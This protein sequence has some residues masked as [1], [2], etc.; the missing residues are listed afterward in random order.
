MILV[1]IP[2]YNEEKN[3][4]RVIRGLFEHGFENIL[5][6]DDGSTDST[7]EAARL[8]G[9]SV[10]RHRINRGQGAALETGNEFARR[11]G[12]EIVVHFDADGQFNPADVR[13]AIER[14]KNGF[15]D[16]ILGSRFMDSRSRVPWFKKYFILPCARI[17]NR[18]FCGIKL[19][20]AHNGFRLLNKNALDKIRI[21]QAGMAHNS[22]I[23][24]AIRDHKLKYTETPVEVTYKEYGQ[25]LVGGIKILKDL[26]ISKF[27][28]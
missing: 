14:M 8:S 18:I 20:D 24:A 3:I 22:E 19:S 7:G 9:A 21:I 15:Y 1:V 4:G 12:V 26:L 5:V 10:I 2:A 17:V 27:I 25:G 23:V 11:S 28:K 16:V 13:P 6:V